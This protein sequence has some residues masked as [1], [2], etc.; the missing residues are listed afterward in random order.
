VNLWRLPN[1]VIAP[2]AL[3]PGVAGLSWL[4]NTFLCTWISIIC[5]VVLFYFGTRRRDDIPSGLQNALEWLIEAFQGLIESVSGKEKGKKFFP[6]VTTFFIFIL[7]A[8]LLDII[9][10]VDTIGTITADHGA[11][12]SQPVLGF[13][14]FGADSNKIIP[15]IRPATTDLN[16]TLAMALVSVVVTQVFGFQ[17]LGTGEH[18]S[19]YFN[20]RAL[21]K[22]G[23]LGAVEFFAGL[24]EIVSELG[25]LISFSFRLFG[26]IF[27]G[28]VLLAVFAF[29]LP[30]VAAIIFIPFE[31]FVGVIQAFVFAFL[32]LL[33]MQVG[34]TSHEHADGQH[35]AVPEYEENV[36]K[37]AAAS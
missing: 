37:E 24:I 6:L 3:F 22:H 2:E 11:L 34:T 4:T 7:F 9:P 12:V 32:T 16:L 1:I 23:P 25:R 30:G 10:G 20:F 19:K 26:N 13:L 33:F 27:A 8:N 31:L 35:E 28:S 14:L 15:W 5:I 36:T 21:L 17:L 18:L 29:L